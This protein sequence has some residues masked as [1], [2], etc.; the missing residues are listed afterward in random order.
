MKIVRTLKRVE[1]SDNENCENI[2]GLSGEIGCLQYLPS[3]YRQ[4]S[5]QVLG[6]VAPMTKTNVEYIS[7]VKVQQMIDRGLTL[8]QIALKHNAGENATECSRGWNKHKVFYDSCAYV[9]K[10]I[11]YYNQLK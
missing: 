9:E 8:K 2:R 7:T 11:N 10:A 1:T 4:Y 3:T 5:I 6:Y